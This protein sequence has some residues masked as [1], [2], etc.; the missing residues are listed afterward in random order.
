M[1]YIQVGRQL[2]HELFECKDQL[3]YI[4]FNKNGDEHIAILVD[5]EGH[6]I[7]AGYGL[8]VIEAINDMHRNLI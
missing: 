7:L 3:K 2:E 1:K 5:L 8:S 6:E 4:K